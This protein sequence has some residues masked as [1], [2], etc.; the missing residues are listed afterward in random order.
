MD[1]P[2]D[3]VLMIAYGGPESMDDVRPF[4]NNIL[5]GKRVNA[6]RIEQVVDQYRQIGGKSPLNDLTRDQARRLEAALAEAG[7]PLPV[8]MGMRN[9]HPFL[10]D[11][12]RELAQAGHRRVLGVICS[13]LQCDSSWDQYQRDVESARETVGATAPTVD[14]LGGCADHPALVDAASEHLRSALDHF[15]G[16]TLDRAWLLFTAHSLPTS[17]PGI[18]MY[19]RQFRS[20][21]E[22]ISGRLD[23]PRWELAYQSRSGRP[24]DPWLEPDAADVIR[25]LSGRGAAAVAVMPIGFVC[26]HTEVLFDLDIGARQVADEVGMGFARARTVGSHP[27]YLNLLAESIVKHTR[28]QSEAGRT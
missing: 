5:R 10:A 27:A 28:R 8:H 21:A 7:L 19:Q 2:Y 23:W 1:Q 14:Y 25:D 16:E 17:M 13:L 20:L 26:D 12:L 6:E 18:D 15:N 3:A 9:W 4:L 24:T 22:R 11:S